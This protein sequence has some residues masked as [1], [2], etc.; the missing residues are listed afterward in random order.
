[1]FRETHPGAVYLHRGGT[2]LIESL[3][4]ETHTVF[5]TLAEVDYYTRVTAHKET[6]ILTVTGK[7]QVG[8][9]WVYT[10]RLR[11]T[12]QVTGYERWQIRGNRRSGKIPLDLPPQVFETDGLWFA[13][14]MHVQEAAA[15]EKL[16]FMGGIHAVEHAAIGI[17]PLLVNG[18][19]K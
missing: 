12:D 14:P 16:H 15:A 8:G 9:A 19:P 3:N 6:Q 18:G 7:K 13:L 10:G 17:F 5:A 4:I 2:F 11:V 1:M